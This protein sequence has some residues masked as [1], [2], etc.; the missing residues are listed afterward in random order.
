M[1]AQSLDNYN[2]KGAGEPARR[3]AETL[4]R[5]QHDAQELPSIYPRVDHERTQDTR[6]VTVICHHRDA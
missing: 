1:S 5:G 6:N 3:C 2:R 4:R